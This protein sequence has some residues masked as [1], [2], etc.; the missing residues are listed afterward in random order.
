MFTTLKL[1]C[2]QERII[3]QHHTNFCFWKN[4]ENDYDMFEGPWASKWKSKYVYMGVCVCERE[5]IL[6]CIWNYICGRE[7]VYFMW[8]TWI[9]CNKGM[10][11][12]E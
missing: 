2:L 5:F 9:L 8:I 6:V 1:L 3:F 10:E 7:H 4:R 11:V 12:L